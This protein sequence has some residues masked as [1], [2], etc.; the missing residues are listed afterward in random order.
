M[1]EK[2]RRRKED[3][4]VSKDCGNGKGWKR[5]LLLAT[6]LMEALETIQNSTFNAATLESPN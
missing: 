6:V 1:R 3:R 5:L 2:Q 4:E